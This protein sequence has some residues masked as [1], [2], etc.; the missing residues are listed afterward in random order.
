M[1]SIFYISPATSTLP[2]QALTFTSLVSLFT[3]ILTYFIKNL[4]AIPTTIKISP[5]TIKNDDWSSIKPATTHIKPTI[6]IEI[7]P[8]L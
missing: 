1:D 7:P 3:R 8:E 2:T 5:I 6:I 4:I